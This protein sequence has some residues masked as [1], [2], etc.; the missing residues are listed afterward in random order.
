VGSGQP[1]METPGAT[2]AARPARRRYRGEGTRSASASG[3]R[4]PWPSRARSSW[5]RSERGRQTRR[6]LLAPVDGEIEFL[7]GPLGQG[8]QPGM[9]PSAAGRFTSK[10]TE[11]RLFSEAGAIGLMHPTGAGELEFAPLARKRT[12]RVKAADS[13]L[14]SQAEL[15]LPSP[16]PPPLATLQ[17]AGDDLGGDFCQVLY[18]PGLGSSVGRARG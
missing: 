7:H 5:R 17:R 16:D 4:S 10:V 13:G 6:L 1:W 15:A 8:T 9:A 3:S 11:I 14:Y 2:S 12:H 18:R